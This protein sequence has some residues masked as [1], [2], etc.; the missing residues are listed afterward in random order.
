MWSCRSV[1]N[2]TESSLKVNS[3]KCSVQCCLWSYGR[4]RS[5]TQCKTTTWISQSKKDY[6]CSAHVVILQRGF[7][8]LLPV[9]CSGWLLSPVPGFRKQLVCTTPCVK[10]VWEVCLGIN[11]M[12]EQTHVMF[13]A[14]I[15]TN[16]SSVFSLHVAFML[17][18]CYFILQLC[19]L[20][21]ER[22]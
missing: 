18:F 7:I 1:S 3:T 14:V 21:I 15:V 19:F 4:P 16:L 8:D 6:V 13:K 11:W 12:T 17:P 10:R 9:E 2:A 20:A 22:F 5:V